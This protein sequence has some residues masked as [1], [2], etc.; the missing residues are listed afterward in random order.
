MKPSCPE[1]ARPLVTVVCDNYKA[2]EDLESC[3]GFSC[4]IR[5]GGKN[6][7]FD[8][9]CD[10]IVLSKNMA[11]LGLDPAAIDLLMISHQH[12]D[13][14]G[15][16]YFIL[17]ANRDL[18]VLVPRSFSP[19]FKADMKRYG[20]PVME[21]DGAQEIFPGFYTTG[22]LNGPVRE[23]AALFR[24]P[25]GVI[26]ITGCAHPGIIH[27]IQ[28]AKKILPNDDLALVMG[29]FHLL[30]DSDKEILKII[31]QFKSLEVRYAAASHCSGE[32][33][34]EL[35]ARAYGSHFIALGAGMEISL[36]DLK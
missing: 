17:D 22:E 35:F 26:V 27:I 34:R 24:T 10:G 12:W 5:H 16:I 15:G 9:G 4:L 25:A 13:H 14:T 1:G 32:R 33:A 6:I 31:E 18:R 23:Q 36:P 28:T 3:W 19:H 30:D 21:A 11:R 2:A 7:L 29:G 8:T 20:V